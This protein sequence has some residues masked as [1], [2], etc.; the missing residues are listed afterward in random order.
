[1]SEITEN[2][3]EISLNEKFSYFLKNGKLKKAKKLLKE[4]HPSEIADIFESTPAKQRDDI[5]SLVDDETKG[6]ILSHMQD[7][8]LEDRLEQ[9]DAEQVI[10]ATK[11]LDDDDVTD[12]LQALPEDKT[13]FVL[14]AMN[15]QNRVRV[16]SLLSYEE[17]T[18]GGLMTIDVVSVRADVKLH[19]VIRYLRQLGELP[20]QTTDLMV[21]DRNDNYIGVLNLSSIL[22]GDRES[23]VGDH[24]EEEVGM[25]ANLP[26]KEVAKFFEQRD[27][28]SAGVVD[29]DN[30][31][32]GRITVDDVVDVIQEEAEQTVMNMAGLKAD[33]DMFAPIFQSTKRRAVWL[34]IN[35]FTAFLAAWVIGQFEATIKEL[36][37]LAVLM[38]IVAGMGGIA[39]SQ[40]LTIAIRGIAVGQLSKSNLKELMSKEVAVGILDGLIWSIVVALIVVFWFDNMSL[41]IVIAA[42][43]I[44]NLTIAAFAG[45]LIPL[46]LKQ[47]GID[48]AI[49]GSVVLTTVTDVVGFFTFLGL[50]TV[51]LLG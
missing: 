27:W 16:S 10:E 4:L 45:A 41:G 37:A 26:A 42:A 15:Q 8:V 2:T 44:I 43:M 31:L 34:G 12:I 49:A 14:D 18:A 7:A 38:P 29:E 46:I 28:F 23:T 3:E 39:G 17:N 22:T 25:P 33:D 9:M 21:V 19:V 11:D 48:P 24:L 35:L 32:L 20:N 40:T 13:E 5:W 6:E 47:Y 50:A 30:K 1:M 51:F 36:V